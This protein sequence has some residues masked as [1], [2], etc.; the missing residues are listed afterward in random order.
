[1]KKF[2]FNLLIFI[3]LSAGAQRT[4]YG[5]GQYAGSIGYFSIGV[6]VTSKKQKAHH[7]LLFGHTPKEFG[8]PLDKLTYKYSWYPFSIKLSKHSDFYPINPTLFAALNFGDRFGL[9]QSYK[10]YDHD[11]YW[12]S[13]G[14]RFHG[15]I[16]MAFSTTSLFKKTK[17]IFYLEANTNDR[18]ITTYY[19]NT[20][21]MG[22]GDLFYLGLGIKVMPKRNN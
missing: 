1:M 8:G 5:V 9:Q 21:N 22:L 2:L 18:Y 13:P 11:Y 7:E 14:L 3:S 12:W 19:D 6:G 16:N 15:G 10:K 20:G 17:T 4:F